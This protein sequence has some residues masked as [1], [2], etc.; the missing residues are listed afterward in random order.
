MQRKGLHNV[1]VRKRMKI[2][3]GQNRQMKR[4]RKVLKAKEMV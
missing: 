4:V 1:A 3:G 2:K